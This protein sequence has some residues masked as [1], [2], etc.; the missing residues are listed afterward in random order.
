M[1]FAV[2][3]IVAGGIVAS[4]SSLATATEGGPG[5]CDV[6]DALVTAGELD[7]ARTLYAL[8][9]A[10]CAT[11]GVAAI[12]E[13]EVAAASLAADGQALV[14]EIP[15]RPAEAREAISLALALDPH[16]AVALAVDETLGGTDLPSLCSAAAERL[17]V[18]E[19][20]TAAALYAAAAGATLTKECGELGVAEVARQRAEALPQRVSAAISGT[21][22]PWLE[23]AAFTVAVIAVL[24]VVASALIR[25]PLKPR[26]KS[27]GALRTAGLVAFGAALVAA[28][29]ILL[30]ALGEGTDILVVTSEPRRWAA[31]HVAVSGGAL[32]VLSGMGTALLAWSEAD[33][34]R[35]AFRPAT[36]SKDADVADLTALIAAEF[37]AFA[38]GAPMSILRLP[39]TELVESPV[40][41]VLKLSSNT[42]VTAAITI[43]KALTPGIDLTVSTHVHWPVN[44]P[45]IA[46]VSLTRGRVELGRQIISG[47]DYA[48]LKNATT[49]RDLA[50]AIAAWVL[51][52][53]RPAI[54]DPVRLY[55]AK[56]WDSVA[57]TAVASRRPFTDPTA[58][59]LLVQAVESNPEN[60]QAQFGL[61]RT[62][63]AG[64]SITDSA[65]VDAWGS[66]LQ[67]LPAEYADLPLGWRAK[68][69]YA[70]ALGNRAQ[71]SVRDGA[72]D[73]A[74]RTTESIG[75]LDELKVVLLPWRDRGDDGS[76][77]DLAV[78]QSAKDR[79]LALNLLNLVSEAREAMSVSNAIA[80]GG[81]PLAVATRIRSEPADPGP[82]AQYNRACAYGVAYDFTV[83]P[84]NPKGDTVWLSEAL[85]CLQSAFENPTLKGY[86]NSDPCLHEVVASS[87]YQALFPSEP[88]DVAQA[89][90]LWSLLVAIRSWWG[91]R[92]DAG[93]GPD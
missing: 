60:M 2:I 12:E 42:A 46:V 54:A 4:T 66:Y 70:A 74:G 85:A 8:L 17:A 83:T 30:G 33:R 36:G 29:A 64:R 48:D 21:L 40:A 10:A 68:Y 35:L 58:R 61:I 1:S 43:W 57:R 9:D 28:A 90:T 56:R 65:Y 91:A 39:A 69:A 52:Q 82:T 37:S 41:T 93:E 14:N 55:G 80:V 13:R 77:P 79:G 34:R 67:A 3:A 72:P 81:D 51:M 26:K 75:A 22:R 5:A 31:D 16:N 44:G 7:T 45:P 92:G 59:R 47:G 89:R 15:P 86:A 23:I 87:E 62:R 6:A 71:Q 53:I 27:A 38:S 76:G 32:V 88:E 73:M 25:N 63:L 84:K 78:G 19:I 20:D 24:G 18:G 49:V 11:R 50:T